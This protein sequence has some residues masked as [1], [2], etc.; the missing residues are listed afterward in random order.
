MFCTSFHCSHLIHQV[1]FDAQFVPLT[2]V[3]L[4]EQQILVYSD[5]F[6]F[7]ICS[8]PI[9]QGKEVGSYLYLDDIDKIVKCEELSGNV[10]SNPYLCI[11]QL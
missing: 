9:L 8:Y 2:F 11:Y 7:H 4:I 10:K 3:S 5:K 1:K 6:C